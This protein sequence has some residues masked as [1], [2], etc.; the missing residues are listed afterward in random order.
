MVFDLIRS[1]IGLLHKEKSRCMRS[2]ERGTHSKK[3]DGTHHP[4][5]H[6]QNCAVITESLHVG[7]TAELDYQYTKIR[8]TIDV[9]GML[10]LLAQGKRLKTEDWPIKPLEKISQQTANF[11]VS[12]SCPRIST[13]SLY[14]RVIWQLIRQD[15]WKRALSLN[16]E[17]CRIARFLWEWFKSF[18]HAAQSCAASC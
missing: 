10:M 6:E 14:M 16:C 2:G 3:C 8:F 11:E 9:N 4:K 18:I 17:F 7:Y 15:R 5:R 12:L 1:Y 13:W